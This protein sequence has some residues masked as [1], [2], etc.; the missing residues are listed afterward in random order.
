[1]CASLVNDSDDFSLVNRARDL[2]R[3]VAA[4]AAGI[5]AQMKAT[6]AAGASPRL[7]A[8]EQKGEIRNA[9][10]RMRQRVYPT[11]WA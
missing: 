1:M 6:P 10:L 9:K 4:F 7:D 8:Q 2:R 11:R 5:G 3:I